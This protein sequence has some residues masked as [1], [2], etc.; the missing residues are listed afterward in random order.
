MEHFPQYRHIVECLAA[1][2][3]NFRSRHQ[4]LKAPSLPPPASGAFSYFENKL[5]RKRFVFKKPWCQVLLRILVKTQ[6]KLVLKNDD[7]GIE[8]STFGLSFAARFVPRG[9]R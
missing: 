3:G 1:A 6:N 7:A 2:T 8:L 9:V 5:A 4:V